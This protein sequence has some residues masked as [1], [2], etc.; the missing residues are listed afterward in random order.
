VLGGFA[1]RRAVSPWFLAKNKNDGKRQQ[2][3]AE[4]HLRAA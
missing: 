2:H 3:L 1:N 4:S